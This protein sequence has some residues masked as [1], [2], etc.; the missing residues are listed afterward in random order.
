[1]GNIV[2]GLVG[3]LLSKK[4]GDRESKDLLAAGRVGAEQFQ[5]FQQA[6]ETANADILAAHGL[7]VDAILKGA[8]S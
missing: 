4:S 7:S 1:M 5:P 2:G 6:G 8:S 3:S